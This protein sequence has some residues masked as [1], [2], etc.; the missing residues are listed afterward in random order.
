MQVKVIFF[1]MHDME[2]D[3][4]HVKFQHESLPYHYEPYFLDKCNSKDMVFCEYAFV[5]MKSINK[6]KPTQSEITQLHV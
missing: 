4:N 6:T 2:D 1:F 5:E 3:I